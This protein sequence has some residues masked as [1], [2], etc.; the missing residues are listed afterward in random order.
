V[1]FA[2]ASLGITGLLTRSLVAA[3]HTVDLERRPRPLTLER[4]ETR[5]PERRRGADLREIRLLVVR[6]LGKGRTLIGQ[7]LPDV[8][9]EPRDCHAAVGV[10]Q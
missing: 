8:V 7:Q 5:L 9:V 2:C 1:I 3:P 6:Q 10:V 4:R